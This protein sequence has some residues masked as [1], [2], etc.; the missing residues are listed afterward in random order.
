MEKDS[1]KFCGKN[2]DNTCHEL[3]SRSANIINTVLVILGLL[4]C[5]TL[6]LLT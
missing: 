3:D 2:C 4:L 5:L 1:C 6:Y